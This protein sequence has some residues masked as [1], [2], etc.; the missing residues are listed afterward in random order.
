VCQLASA[1]PS[2]RFLERTAEADVLI[3]EADAVV[4]MGG[5]NSVCSVLSYKKPALVIPRVVPRTEQLIRAERLAKRGLVDWIHPDQLTPGALSRW[6]HTV[7]PAEVDH[8]DRI[9]MRGLERIS[10]LVA[11]LLTD[12]SDFSDSKEHLSYAI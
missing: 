1:N 2:V 11:D 5:Y 12:W 9:D 10:M 7:A 8:S 3:R 4:T 6:M